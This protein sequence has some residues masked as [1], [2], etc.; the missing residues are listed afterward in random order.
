MLS[1]MEAGGVGF[2]VALLA[3]PVW[4]RFLLRRSYGQQIRE[5]GPAHQHKVGT[6]TMGG[7]IIML[8]ALIGY[9][10]GHLGT[11]ITIT[12]AGVLAISVTLASGLLGLVDDLLAIRNARNLGLNKRGKFAGQFVIAATFAV[13]SILW[14]HTSTDLSFTRLTL[15]GWNLTA[16]GWIILAIFVIIAT[17]NAVNL[18]D[19]LDGLAAGSATFCFGVLSIIGY[20]QFRHF[21]IYQ[22]H[23]ALDLGLVAVALVGACLGFLWWNAAPAKIIMGDTGSLAIGTALGAICL[24]MNLDLLLVII[25]GLFV[26][27]T[28]SVI[29][30]VLSFRLF[31]RRIFRMAP[32]HHH[33][34]L[35]GWPETTIIIRLWI[36]AGLLAALGL[37]LFYGDFLK[38]GGVV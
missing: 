4:I 13:L 5:D 10:M 20:W 31:G 38:I 3:T 19:G 14:V 26:A 30:Q 36:L 9:L 2:L 24:L 23:A 22:L 34:E 32:F 1:L 28:A 21:S 37:G 18:T 7:V 35:L 16:T 33:F 15:P 12:R 27:E 25:G 11:S 8:A 6:P 29:L 17:S